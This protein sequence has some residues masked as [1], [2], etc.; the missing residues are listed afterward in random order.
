ML[1][2]TVLAMLIT[3]FAQGRPRYVSMEPGQRIA[4]ISDVGADI[5]KPLFIVGCGIAAVGFFLSLAVERWLRHEGRL[6]PNMRRREKVMSSLAIFSSFI[7]GGALILLSVFDTKNHVTAHRVFLLFF[8]LGVVLS[9]IF[10]V[11]EYKWLDKEY[12][13]DLIRLRAAY[14]VKAILGGMLV[15]LAIAFGVLLNRN[16]EAAAVLEW[17]ITLHFTA[18]LLTFWYDL[19]QSK[20]VRRGELLND[21]MDERRTGTVSM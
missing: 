1:L 15:I 5:L 13:A 19:H 6:H 8:A 14:I 10:T 12:G 20:G 2:F 7:G 16:Q 21:V 11:M 4:Y 9:A 3:W 18:Y 17:I